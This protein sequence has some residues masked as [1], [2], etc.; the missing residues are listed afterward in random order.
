MTSGVHVTKVAADHPALAGHFPDRPIVPGV[1][2]L[3][4]AV[5]AAR[6][7]R[8]LSVAQVVSVKFHASLLPGESCEMEWSEAADVVRF[9]CSSGEQLIA[10]GSF[11]WHTSGANT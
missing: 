11:R 6:G 2:L 9:R 1:L 5:D 8:A 4:L 10:E 3:E 7:G